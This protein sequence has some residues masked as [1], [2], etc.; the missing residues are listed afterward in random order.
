MVFRNPFQFTPENEREIRDI[1]QLLFA[2]IDPLSEEETA[3]LYDK[4]AVFFNV[5]MECI[6]PKYGH[7][8]NFPFSGGA[9]NQPSMTMKALLIIQ[10]CYISQLKKDYNKGK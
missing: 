10:S 9:F 3:P 8:E 7:F 6:N 2:G 1:A 4:W 5:F